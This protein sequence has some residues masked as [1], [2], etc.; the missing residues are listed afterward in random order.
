MDKLL[1]LLRFLV[2]ISMRRYMKDTMEGIRRRVP[3]KQTGLPKYGLGPTQIYPIGTNFFS[4]LDAATR[5]KLSGI[6]LSPT[7]P[8]ASIG[9]CFAEEFAYFMLD[10]GYNYVRTESDVLAASANWG[11]VY[12]IPNL[13]QIVRYSTERSY[14]LVIEQSEHGWFDPLR[15]PRA[16]YSPSFK[17]AGEAILAH[18][19]AS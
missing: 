2:P 11:R 5:E 4:V 1:H 19:L 12:T 13:L 10:R 6:G 18:R 7:T 14:P 15:E 9:T 17:T 3:G 8:V 16:S